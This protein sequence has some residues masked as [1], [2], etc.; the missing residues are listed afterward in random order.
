[1]R[2]IKSL[3]SPPYR[4]LFLGAT[5]LA[6]TA[7]LSQ[8]SRFS[9]TTY[10]A[11]GGSATTDNLNQAI[12]TLSFAVDLS[13]TGAYRAVVQLG[14]GSATWIG[15]SDTKSYFLTAAHIVNAASNTITTHNGTTISSKTGS[16][17]YTADHDFGLLEYDGVLNP[18]LFGDAPA[19]LMDRNTFNNFEG[20]VTALVGYGTLI[21]NDRSLGRTRMLSTANVSSGGNMT[22]SNTLNLTTK[23]RAYAGIASGGDSG[24]GIFLQLAERTVL[25]GASSGGNGSNAFNYTNIYDNKDLIDSIVPAEAFTWYRSIFTLRK[26]NA[27]SYGIDGGGG[28][29]DGQNVYLWGHKQTNINQQWDELDRGSSNYSYRKV[30]TDHSMDGGRGGAKGQNVY[31]WNTAPNNQ[32]QHWNK[33]R[34]S[35]DIYRLRKRN[36]SGFAIDGGRRRI[37]RPKCLHV[38]Q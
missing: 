1:M 36:K 3:K 16:E 21:I 31:L 19:I 32:N 29:E 15:N 13:K 12:S 26:N 35:G 9:A 4:S 24:G 8:A 37:K 2:L 7:Q 28:A 5:M 23:S 34:V 17:F 33:V 38:V 30:A 14:A 6:S 10:N 11:L 25:V 27:R 20:E 22:W 18:S